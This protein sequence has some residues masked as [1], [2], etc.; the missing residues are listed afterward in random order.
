MS[1]DMKTTVKFSEL[2]AEFDV[3]FT[4]LGSLELNATLQKK[5]AVQTVAKHPEEP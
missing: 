1:S 3:E 4:R 2:S 5:G